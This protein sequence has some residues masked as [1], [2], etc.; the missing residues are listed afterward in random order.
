MGHNRGKGGLQGL[1]GSWGGEVSARIL[2]LKPDAHQCCRLV[3]SMLCLASLL[4]AQAP[5][6][7]MKCESDDKPYTLQPAFL[8]A[9]LKL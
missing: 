9:P 6:G 8:P 3:D 4:N 5:F 7:N 2:P 1:D